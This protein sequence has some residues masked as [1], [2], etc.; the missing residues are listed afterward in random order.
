KGHPYSKQVIGTKESIQSITRQDLINFYKKHISPSGARMAIVGD[1][2]DY[3]LK[4][5]LETKLQQ[6]K[7]RLVEE[8]IFP[9]LSPCAPQE[10]N[11]PINRDQV[12]LCLAQL[13]IDRKDPDYDK[14]LL[15]D[16]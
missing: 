6:W 16:Q 8:T 13:S 10:I 14:Y 1:I 5:L 12:A 3:K 15:F 4:E 9:Q 11:Y 2:R 7:A